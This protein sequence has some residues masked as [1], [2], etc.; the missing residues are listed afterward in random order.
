MDVFRKIKARKLCCIIRSTLQVKGLLEVRGSVSDRSL[1]ERAEMGT[2]TRRPCSLR[3]P[4]CCAFQDT[5]TPSEQATQREAL[6]GGRRVGAG[7]CVCHHQ[8]QRPNLARF[9]L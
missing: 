1:G 4:L 3:P 9:L 8:S 5:R 7:A 2:L 6:G